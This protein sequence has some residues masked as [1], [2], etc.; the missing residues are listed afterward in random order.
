MKFGLMFV[1]GHQITHSASNN[2]PEDVPGSK[3]FS[4]RLLEKL[5][6]S[7]LQSSHSQ[8]Y[9]PLTNSTYIK[10][11]RKLKKTFVLPPY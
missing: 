3:I 10:R 11:L 1:L 2:T 4:G 9:T 7:A 5:R 8:F 6:R